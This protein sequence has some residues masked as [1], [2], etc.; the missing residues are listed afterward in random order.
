MLLPWFKQ[1]WFH[2]AVFTFIF[3]VNGYLFNVYIPYSQI[4]KRWIRF[5]TPKHNLIWS[6]LFFCSGA[7]QYLS[8]VKNMREPERLIGSIGLCQ[9]LLYWFCSNQVRQ[10][11]S[12]WFKTVILPSL[13]AIEVSRLNLGNHNL[14]VE[15]ADRWNNLVR[16]WIISGLICDA[17]SGIQN[18][19]IPF[20]V[21]G[22]WSPYWFFWLWVRFDLTSWYTSSQKL[23]LCCILV[24]CQIGL[25]SQNGQ[26]HCW[27]KM[28][29]IRLYESVKIWFACNL[30]HGI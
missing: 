2:L 23:L 15:V 19:D 7:L 26:V 9:E 28:Y 10:T 29:Q 5:S 21:L 8:A 17:V 16:F 24:V 27:A 30:G 22:S 12:N 4:A 18:G 6:E 25:Y 13:Q 1:W 20:C 3:N 14:R 11:K